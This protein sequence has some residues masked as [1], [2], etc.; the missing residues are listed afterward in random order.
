MLYFLFV[1][2]PFIYH[3]SNVVLCF[4]QW[5]AHWTDVKREI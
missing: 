2:R 4:V 5:S 1:F 3:V